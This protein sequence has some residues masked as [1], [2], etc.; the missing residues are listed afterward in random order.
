MITK[1]RIFISILFV[2]VSTTVNA[3]FH[4]ETVKNVEFHKDNFSKEQRKELKEAIKQIKEADEYYDYKS[5]GGYRAALPYYYKANKFNPNNAKVNYRVGVCYLHGTIF[6][7]KSI[8]FFLKAYSLDPHVDVEDAIAGSVARAWIVG[9]VAVDRPRPDK[10]DVLKLRGRAGAEL[11]DVSLNSG[12]VGV[13]SQRNC[14]AQVKHDL[15]V[16]PIDEDRIGVGPGLPNGIVTRQEEN[17]P[18]VERLVDRGLDFHLVVLAVA[19][20]VGSPLDKRI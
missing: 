7:T 18:A 9:G 3:Q 11:E 15:Q 19:H 17:R 6:K 20:V 1:F 4:T 8:N 14:C 16:R 12:R 2:V 5:R 13:V 10:M